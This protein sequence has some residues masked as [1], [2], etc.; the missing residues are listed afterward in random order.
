MVITLESSRRPCDSDALATSS[1]EMNFAQPLSADTLVSAAVSVVL[2]WSMCPIVPTFT[3]G[4][5]RSNFSLA[6]SSTS[7]MSYRRRCRSTR[8]R[9]RDKQPACRAEARVASASVHPRASRCGGQ[10]SNGL[11]TE[12]RGASEG[13][14]RCP[15]SNWRPRPYQGRALPTELHRP[16]RSALRPTSRPSFNST[17][18]SR[19]SPTQARG[20]SRWSANRSSR[21]ERTPWP[22]NRSSRS[23]RT[24]WPANRSSRSERRLERET[25]IEPATNSL[26]GCD[27]TTELLPHLASFAV[28]IRDSGFGIRQ[29]GLRP[30]ALAARFT[31]EF[32]TPA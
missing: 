7:S 13:W 5:L 19:H 11:P 22:A 17:R 10:P 2:P 29:P 26:E 4:L 16:S 27:S 30:P 18:G 15:G 28:G 8:P 21:S 14:S 23:E 9:R 24:P 25:G 6:M 3:W 20:S 31:N 1:Y 12:A 32:A